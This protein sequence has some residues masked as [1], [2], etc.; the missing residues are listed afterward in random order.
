MRI[1]DRP[2]TRGREAMGAVVYSEDGCRKDELR[3]TFRGETHS[4]WSVYENMR[5]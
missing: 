5:S 2:V 4:D 3:E 1:I